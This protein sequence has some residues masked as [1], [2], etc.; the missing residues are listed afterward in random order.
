MGALK[1]IHM[2]GKDLSDFLKNIR[3]EQGNNAAATMEKLLRQGAEGMPGL[4]KNEHLSAKNAVLWWRNI[5]GRNFYVPVTPV[6]EA[7][8][9][10]TVTDEERL[11][12]FKD[13]MKEKSPL[14]HQ[15]IERLETWRKADYNLRE[16]AQ[17]PWDRDGQERVALNSRIKIHDLIGSHLY[18]EIDGK[19]Y[20]FK[21]DGHTAAAYNVGR[22]S[23][24]AIGNRL[25]EL[26]DKS[27]QGQQHLLLYEQQVA[28]DYK[29]RLGE[30]QGLHI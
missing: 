12:F 17:T 13:L 8:M 1:G 18:A 28:D 25:L 7:R 19:Q 9:A 6:E 15:A 21:I 30:K 26:F 22:I 2:I 5:D 14:Q 29:E 23:L 16:I 10:G 27:P 11:K 3:T 20:K 24:N 4:I